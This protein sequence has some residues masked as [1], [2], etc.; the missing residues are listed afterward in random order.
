M[1]CGLSLN[2]Y[3]RCPC[4]VLIDTGKHV[5]YRCHHSTDATSCLSVKRVALLIVWWDR[6]AGDGQK[7]IG[8]YAPLFD[9]LCGRLNW[10]A[11]VAHR[12]A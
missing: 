6:R 9:Y 12:A 4:A 1:S 8:W 11:V 2:A 10:T 7:G 5:G 3:L